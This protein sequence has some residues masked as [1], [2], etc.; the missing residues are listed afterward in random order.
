MQSAG[1]LMSEF[2][3]TEK[4]SGIFICCLGPL[5]CLLLNLINSIEATAFMRDTQM[6]ESQPQSRL[7]YLT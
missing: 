7:C 6:F 3:N 1:W 5:N 2:P 4:R